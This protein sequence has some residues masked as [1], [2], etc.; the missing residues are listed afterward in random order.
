M[1]A[2]RTTTTAKNAESN[3]ESDTDKLID[4]CLKLV[5]IEQPLKV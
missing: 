3:F 4:F 2:T 5:R 1:C